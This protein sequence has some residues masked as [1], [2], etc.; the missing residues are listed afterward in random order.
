MFV[1]KG[2][3]FSVTFVISLVVVNLLYGTKAIFPTVQ[4]KQVKVVEVKKTEAPSKNPYKQQ[5]VA[6]SLYKGEFE[7]IRDYI[8]T[9]GVKVSKG[10]YILDFTDPNGNRLNLFCY[11]NSSPQRIEAFGFIGKERK[12][13]E[14]FSYQVTSKSGIMTMKDDSVNRYISEVRYGFANLSI[15]ANSQ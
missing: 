4:S 15:L 12:E 2:M 5:P 8:I 10:V 3:A 14:D 7:K 9:N 6:M 1:D 13:Y 11:A